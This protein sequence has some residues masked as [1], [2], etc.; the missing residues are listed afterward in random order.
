M[1]WE[2][3]FLSSAS[4]TGA[5]EWADRNNFIVSP[6]IAAPGVAKVATHWQYSV[7][8]G[9]SVVDGVVVK[10]GREGGRQNSAVDKV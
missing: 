2:L 3:H 7:A 6:S 9:V 4:Q 5:G 8:D 10:G 1:Q